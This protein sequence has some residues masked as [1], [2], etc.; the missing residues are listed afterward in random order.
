MHHFTE[1]AMRIV[2]STDMS[3]EHKMAAILSLCGTKLSDTT[4]AL[5]M[6][7][8]FVEESSIDPDTKEEMLE[9]FDEFIYE[10]RQHEEKLVHLQRMVC[11]K[12]GHYDKDKMGETHHNH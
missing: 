10:A 5:V 4:T 9:D 11:H 6:A 3:E 7:R 12:I 8:G 2:K 1:S